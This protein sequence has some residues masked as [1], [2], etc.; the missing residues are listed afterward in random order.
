MEVD[1][2]QNWGF[3]NSSKIHNTPKKI[4]WIETW[5]WRIKISKAYDTNGSMD[6]N[7]PI[8]C[9]GGII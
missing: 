6:N 5:T 2:S 9:V 7:V 3:F 8:F 4:Q 1:F